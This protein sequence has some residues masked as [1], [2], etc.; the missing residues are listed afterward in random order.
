M[1]RYSVAFLVLLWGG[2]SAM[3]DG[4]DYR[5]SPLVGLKDAAKAAGRSWIQLTNEQWEFVRAVAALAPATPEGLPPGDSAAMVSEPN[6][7]A[8]IF[9]IDED[10]ACE[11]I[12]VFS[13]FAKVIL[14]VGA[15]KIVHQES[16]G[17][18]L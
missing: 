5:C 2:S 6:G 9:F 1:P 15:G 13:K 14:D 16:A 3:A 18:P 17:A 11:G 4:P 12:E 10:K 7:D 8:A